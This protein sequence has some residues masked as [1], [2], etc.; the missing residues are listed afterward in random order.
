[1]GKRITLSGYDAEH[2][3]EWLRM[4]W[5]GAQQRFGGC[6]DCE[7]IGRRLERLIGSHEVRRIAALVKKVPGQPVR[8]GRY[9]TDEEFQRSADKMFRKHRM[10]LKRLAKK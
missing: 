3:Y 4:Y 9:A 10:V 6:Y 8:R 2:V 5:R 1:M 7:R